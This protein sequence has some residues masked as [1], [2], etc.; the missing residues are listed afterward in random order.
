MN[1]I[2]KIKDGEIKL[3]EAKNGQIKF[4]LVL[5]E[6]KKRKQKKKKK[7]KSKNA[8]YNNEVL[9][10]ARN[11]TIKFHNEY[12]LMAFEAKN[13]AKNK[14]SGKGLKMLTPKQLLQR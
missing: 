14:R 6:I 7:S 5:G 12:Y 10:K 3:A 4:K 8:L 13:K 1:L 9:F 2:D 11:E